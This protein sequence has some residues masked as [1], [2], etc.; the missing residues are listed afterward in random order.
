MDNPLKG[1]Y[2][3]IHSLPAQFPLHIVLDETDYDTIVGRTFD[4][5]FVMDR[6]IRFAG[7]IS[8]A[9]SV[10]FKWSNLVS[11]KVDRFIPRCYTV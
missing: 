7:K 11:S 5:V 10:S 8:F 3:W 4:Y 2:Y 6:K 9:L 1:R